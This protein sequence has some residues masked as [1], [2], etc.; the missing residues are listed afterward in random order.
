MDLFDAMQVVVPSG[1]DFNAEISVAREQGADPA[2][3]LVCGVDEVGRGP[4]AGPVVAAAVILNPTCIPVGLDDSKRLTAKKR[5]ALYEGILETSVAYA[6]AQ[7]SVEEIDSL[8][9]LEASM[10]AMRRAVAG[11]DMVPMAALVDG[12]RDPGLGNIH[13]RTLIKGDSR[14]LSIAAASILAKVFRDR[15]MAKLD[16]DFPQYGWAQNA[17]YGVEKHR[18]ALKLVGVTPHHRRSFAPIRYILDEE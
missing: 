7:A 9:I 15:L 17:G 10:L 2:M 8:N 14:S 1:P 11:L 3:P 5:E 13:T 6:I 4:L 16:E 18:Q 12:N